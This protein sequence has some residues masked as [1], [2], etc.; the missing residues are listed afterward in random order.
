MPPREPFKTTSFLQESKYL[1]NA[2][3]VLLGNIDKL[4]VAGIKGDAYSAG[5]GFDGSAKSSRR[6]ID[7]LTDLGSLDVCFG[8]F[9]PTAMGDRS[10][11]REQVQRA[12]QRAREREEAAKRAAAIEAARASTVRQWEDET[13]CV[14]RY[15][16]LDGTQIRIERCV[17]PD[18]VCDLEIPACIEGMPV[19]AL[20]SEACAQLK[21]VERIV[22]PPTIAVM[23][24]C[25][26]RDC[27]A[28]LRVEFSE[29][30]SSYDSGWLRGCSC[31]ESMKLP[32]QLEKLT[33][34]VFDIPT[35]RTLILG[36]AVSEIMPGSFAKSQLT[37]IE[38]DSRNPYIATDGRGIYSHDFSIL[39]A[40]AVPVER[41]TV[42]D[43]CVAICRKGFSTFEQLQDVQLPDTLEVIGDF[44]YSRTGIEKFDAPQSLKLIG[45][46]AFFAC[47]NLKDAVLNYGLVGIGS[48]AFSDT[49]I[50]ELRIPAS[51]IELGNPI[52]AHTSLT[53]SGDDASFSIQE[54]DGDASNLLTLDKNGG[55]Y[56]KA[57]DGV[58]FVRMLE[59]ATQQYEVARNTTYIDDGAC[60][61]HQNLQKVV[62][63]QG[64]IG[65]GKAAFKDCRNLSV[66]NLPDTLVSIGDEAFLDTN[67]R[68]LRIPQSLVRIGSIA[69]ITHGAHHGTCEPS[70][71]HVEVDSA[72]PRFRMDSG[73]LVERLDSGTERVVLC[74]GEVDDVVVPAGVTVISPYAFNGVRSIRTLSI[75][76]RVQTV[77][78]RGLAFDC[79]PDCIRV[80]L[81]EPVHGHDHFDFEFPHTSRA[82]QQLRLAF[83]T[84]NF[85]DPE[86]IFDH[87]DN[88][89]VNRNGFDAENEGTL[90]AYEQVRL[91]VA[92]MRD[93]VFMSSTNRGLMESALRSHIVE[94]CVD[95]ARHDDK[96]AIDSLLDLGFIDS[97]NISQI[98]EAVRSVQ[99]ASITNHLL[100]QKRRRFG[101]ASIDFD[102]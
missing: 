31:V 8:G 13:G 5:T 99:D 38:V 37:R 19:V 101:I 7:P 73:L 100:D 82:T 47:S 92:R 55:L 72:N 71:R 23:G 48:H 33:P 67:L 51:I 64:L 41:Y 81:L 57:E 18:D 63:P 70:L 2:M 58:H 89:I 49:F 39:I 14:W 69:L 68:E 20:A 84:A 22:M 54:D 61:K 98:I 59:P 91:M 60:S 80:E 35:L 27:A 56:R 12:E 44:A 45:E 11:T 97:E 102:L 74:T 85:V 34:S 28:L 9:S 76:E 26:F 4:N 86:G 1:T 40:L 79:L 52:A 24:Y 32:G 90:G 77:D 87:Y 21:F 3:S 30:L 25:V 29:S 17:C 15:V 53:Y 75:H 10:T 93:P 62:L 46:R 50:S 42:N 95:I 6:Q 94:Y 43:A 36:P 96:D 65:I 16:V 78:V 88:A 83:G 66:V